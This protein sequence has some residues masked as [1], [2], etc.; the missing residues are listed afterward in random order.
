MD[1]KDK[2]LL[3]KTEY[4][5]GVSLRTIQLWLIAGALVVS[6]LI[7]Y[8]TYNLSVSFRNFTD[9]SEE[10]V[11]MRK[12]AMELMDASDYLT[13]KVQSFSVHGDIRFLNEY[14][15]E[16]MQANHREEAIASMSGKAGFEP[17]LHKLLA[18]ME[19]SLNLMNRE[20]YS[21]KLVVEA[22]GIENYPTVIRSVV[23]SEE[24]KALS[25]DEKMLRAAAMVH[26]DEYYAQKGKIRLNMRASLKELEQI[27]YTNDEMALTDFSKKMDWVRLV[28]I[29]QTVSIF[30]MVWL[31]SRLGILPILNAV[32]RIKADSPIPED[33]VREFRYLAR[34]YNQMYEIYKNSLDRLNFKASHDELTG[35]Y[36]RSGYELLLS[37]IDL[38][39][40]YMMLVDVDNFK[41]INDTYGHE[42]G[43]RVLSQLVKILK[44]NFRSDDYVCRIGGDEFVVF[45]IHINEINQKM[46]SSKIERI[47]KQLTE[48]GDD[49][50]KVSISVGITHGTEVSDLESLF[51]KTDEAM[52]KSKQSGKGTYTFH[53]N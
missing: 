1:A 21:M 19:G 11:D 12:A 32:E 36:N 8:F 50:P 45:M 7:F 53:S 5:E 52:Y 44:K 43:D 39:S 10:Q 38:G 14:F 13:E 46:V 25:P 24:D 20:Y 3:K 51:K 48:L 18:A 30:F 31:T 9:K 29:L 27:T 2:Q 37:S 35:A 16:A 33:G 28:I 49:M 17:A 4:K 26:D 22:K 42:V 47:N 15:T 6:C 41:Q 40:T 34:T 23:L